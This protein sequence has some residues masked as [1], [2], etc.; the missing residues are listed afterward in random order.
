VKS[1]AEAL[2]GELTPEGIDVLAICPG[3]TDTEALGRHGIDPTTLP[4]V[5]SPDAVAKLAL[6]NLSQGPVLITSEHY[7][8]TFDRLLSMP[9]RDALMAMAA[10]M[11]P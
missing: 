2:W 1:L 9:R 8:A 7:R 10:R 5:M 6:E 11:K 3:A 4:N